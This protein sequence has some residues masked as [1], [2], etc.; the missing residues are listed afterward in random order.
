[1]TPLYA[2]HLGLD[3]QRRFRRCKFEYVSDVVYILKCQH[4][5]ATQE[6]DVLKL[7]SGPPVLSRP[8]S[9]RTR[10]APTTTVSF[11]GF[12]SSTSTLCLRRIQSPLQSLSCTQRRYELFRSEPQMHKVTKASSIAFAVLILTTTCFPKIGH[13]RQFSIKRSTCRN[14]AIR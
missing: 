8:S 3:S 7:L 6:R 12:P 14:E 9:S 10:T 2:F 13:R 11:T 5:Q 1:M 4:R